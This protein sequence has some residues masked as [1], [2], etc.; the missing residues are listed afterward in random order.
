V[1]Q[2]K[3][4]PTSG[5][6]GFVELGRGRAKNDPCYNRE[7]GFFVIA[8]EKVF[9]FQRDWHQADR[10]KPLV[11]QYQIQLDAVLE[12]HPDLQRCVT[13]CVYCGIR[14]LTH[15]RNTGRRDLRCP[16]GC[17]RE[18]RLE[19]SGQRSKAYRQ[20]ARGKWKKQEFNRRRYRPRPAVGPQPAAVDLPAP[21]AQEP[22]IEDLPQS[23]DSTPP[24]PP[25]QE[26]RVDDLPQP[27]ASDRPATQERRSDDLPSPA[28]GDL[29]ATPP[30]EPRTGDL[31]QEAELCLEGV[32]LRESSLSTSPVLP[33]VRM[34]VSLIEGVEFSCQEVVGWLRK[35]LRQ[36]SIAQRPR[37]E[38]VLRFLHQHPP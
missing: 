21:P 28:A 5:S 35:V 9:S 3:P 29:P 1:A 23:V 32:L 33:Y 24:A 14:F 10:A 8:I 12:S 27:A 37:R 16:F 22:G 26:P 25:V 11:R 7:S 2:E 15:P 19:R 38:Y 36:H 4:R 31:P 17:R 18:H 6:L 34:V 13:Q 30:Q 20:T